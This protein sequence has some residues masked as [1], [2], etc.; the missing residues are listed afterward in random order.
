MQARRG[1]NRKPASTYRFVRGRPAELC[2]RPALLSMAASTKRN[3]HR[4]CGETRWPVQRRRPRP[5]GLMPAGAISRVPASRSRKAMTATGPRGGG[6]DRP[7]PQRAPNR[8]R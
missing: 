8:E 2:R 1:L 4:V 6:W 5:E 7:P 3:G